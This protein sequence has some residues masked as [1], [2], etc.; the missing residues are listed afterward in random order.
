MICEKCGHILRVGDW[1]YCKGEH[2]KYRGGVITDDIPGGQV[3]ENLGHTPRTFYSK[4]AIVKAAAEQGLQ[5][6]VRHVEGDKH[7]SRW[8]GIDPQTLANAAELVTRRAI[9]SRPEPADDVVCETAQFTVEA[10]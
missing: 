1:P 9:R 7:L 4:Q 2:G 10:K 6:M 5:P 3:I 8:A